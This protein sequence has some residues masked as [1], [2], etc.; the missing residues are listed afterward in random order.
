MPAQSHLFVLMCCRLVELCYFLARL[1][2]SACCVPP[3]ALF[4]PHLCTLSLL[5]ALSLWTTQPWRSIFLP[6]PP[7]HSLLLLLALAFSLSTLLALFLSIK[8]T[9]HLPCPLFKTPINVSLPQPSN[10]HIKKFVHRSPFF[11]SRP[12]RL[13]TLFLQMPPP[14]SNL[15]F[16]PPSLVSMFILFVLSLTFIFKVRRYL[17]HIRYDT[18]FLFHIRCL[19]PIT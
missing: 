7:A 6:S 5:I 13:V 2:L 15:F 17:L 12:I 3:T 9:Q 16:V 1:P 18:L 14:T 19:H 10:P 4:C 11:I 8:D